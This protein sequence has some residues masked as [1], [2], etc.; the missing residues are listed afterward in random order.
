ME[1][2]MQKENLNN[3]NTEENAVVILLLTEHSEHP[4][5]QERTV[6]VLHQVLLQVE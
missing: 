4:T 1:P 5:D 6:L 2:H 3:H